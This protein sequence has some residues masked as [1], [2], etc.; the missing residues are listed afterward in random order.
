MVHLLLSFDYDAHKRH[1]RS[2][3]TA[4]WIRV[5]A[6]LPPLSFPI[7][8]QKIRIRILVVFVSTP[9]SN[10]SSYYQCCCYLV[11]FSIV[12]CLNKP[13]TKRKSDMVNIL[14]CHIDRLLSFSFISIKCIEYNGL[15]VRYWS[16]EVQ[17]SEPC[18]PPFEQFQKN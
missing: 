5:F 8:M 16:P 10:Y 4:I 13:D 15:N 14:L 6:T 2:T 12:T 9:N 18:R 1:S 11:G 3:F 17:S 7:K